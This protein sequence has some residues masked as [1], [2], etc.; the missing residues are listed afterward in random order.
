MAVVGWYERGGWTRGRTDL[1]RILKL[2]VPLFN[3]FDGS[4]HGWMDGHESAV[5]N[6]LGIGTLITYFNTGIS[7][8]ELGIGV[9]VGF[10]AYGH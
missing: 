6:G 8:A 7:F 3:F 9:L 5:V 2:N 1:L 4:R 10:I